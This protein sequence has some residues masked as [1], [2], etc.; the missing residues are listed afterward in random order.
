MTASAAS[1]G[2]LTSTGTLFVH[3][4]ES[5][6]RFNGIGTQNF[7]CHAT[8]TIGNIDETP[9]E[10]LDVP[11]TEITITPDY[12]NCSA[13]ENNT[14]LGPATVT[15]NGCDFDLTI[16][17]NISPGK[18]H[19]SADIT[20]PVVGG[21]Q[22]QIEVHVYSSS[23]HASTL[24]TYKIPAQQNLGGGTSEN[25]GNGNVLLGGPVTGIHATR[26]GILCGGT[27]E[28]NNAQ[29]LINTEAIGLNEAAEA[30]PMEVT[31]S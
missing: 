17:A 30:T 12:T 6:A 15:M 31:G 18:Y 4:T 21:V 27:A 28:T 23:S 24:C 10:S 20:C 16:G 3:A 19:Y 8:Y 14:T 13:F 9:H 29:Q 25:L 11:T 2:E 7:R 1:A 22:Q 26:T 5:V